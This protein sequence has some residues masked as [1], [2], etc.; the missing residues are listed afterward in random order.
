MKY[1]PAFD[2]ENIARDVIRKLEMAHVNEGR[3]AFFRSKG[4]SARGVIARCHGLSKIQQLGLKVEPF[5]VI[6]LISENFDKLSE[7][8]KIRTVIHELMHI[9]HN[10]GGGFRH[11]NFVNRKSV[12][13][14]YKKFIESEKG[15]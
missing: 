12:D 13:I 3:I 9:P 8:E 10:F 15:I 4:T 2:V 11:H 14:L 6:E 7:S 1:F 5:Y